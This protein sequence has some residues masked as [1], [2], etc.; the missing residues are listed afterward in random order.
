[1]KKLLFFL[2]SI[3]ST[4]TQAQNVLIPDQN[5][6]SYLLAQLAINTNSDTE[7][8]VSE[9]S[10]FTGSINCSGQG[11]TDLTGIEAFTSLTQ[12][13]CNLNSLSGI[14]LNSNT[15]LTHL[16]FSNNQISY[17][18]L[19]QNTALTYI[20]CSGNTL[21]YINTN[22]MPNL[23][24]LYCE[25][26]SINTLYLGNNT[27]LLKL[28]CS[29]NWLSNLDVHS[30]TALNEINCA[31]N[32]SIISLDFSLNTALM[33]ITCNDNML[34]SL[35]VKNGINTSIS[36][37]NFKA[38]NNSNLN[39][40]EVDNPSYS[41]TNWTN[42]DPTVIYNTNCTSTSLNSLNDNLLKMNIYPNPTSSL[43]YIEVKEQKQLSVVNVLGDIVLKQ[44]INGLSKIDVS[45]LTSGVYFIQDSKSGK[46]IKFIK[47]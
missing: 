10:A 3:T 46:A 38:Y 4:I 35:N 19:D 28:N 31:Y 7:I 18:N 40:I 15:A 23:N 9:A 20:K 21:T 47:E 39:C 42:V 29:Q 13:F 6:K 11:I 2:A 44:T 32:S 43:L 24:Y 26:N 17:I 36:N 41:A 1:M 25:Q 12:L 5:F 45:N 8:Q 16:D 34:T 30:N 14:Y 22:L 27:N 33:T 37:T